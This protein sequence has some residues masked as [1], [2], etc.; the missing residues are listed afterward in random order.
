MSFVEAYGYDIQLAIYQE[1]V[2]QSTGERLPAYICA[3][4][5]EKVPNIEIIG[6]DQIRL[7]ECL[8]IVK[9]NAMHYNDIKLGKAEP[10]KCNKCD[11][12]KS[13]K[14]IEHPI[15]YLELN[16][17]INRTEPQNNPVSV[18]SIVSLPSLENAHTGENNAVSLDDK[19]KKKK[20]KKKGKV[21]VIKL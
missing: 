15:N 20:K 3:V 4:T 2:Y 21:I 18:S 13:I 12:C 17:E 1:L 8:E 6:I 16:P 5:K 19:S 11:Y 14:K 9:A 10:T 7:D